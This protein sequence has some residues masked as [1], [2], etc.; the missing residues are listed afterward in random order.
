MP[1]VWRITLVS[2]L[3][4][5][6]LL[7]LLS[8]I[9]YKG[10]FKGHFTFFDDSQE[11]LQM[12]KMGHFFASF[13]VSRWFIQ[14]LKWQKVDPKEAQRI[15]VW[16]GILFVS[17]IEVLDG[18]SIAYGFSWTDILANVM[19]SLCLWLQYRVFGLIRF[20]PK[21]S[22]SFSPFASMRKEM[23]GGF[24]LSQLIKDY[25]AQTYWISCSPNL[26][27]K[28]KLFPEWLHIS[29]GYGGD[30]LLGGHDNVWEKEG[31][32]FDFSDLQRVRQ[33]Y[34]SF[35]LNFQYLEGTSRFKRGLKLV[36]SCLKFPFPMIGFD[37]VNGLFFRWL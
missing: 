31:R 22:F 2:F 33:F 3:I 5:A 23:L 25:N 24:F 1:K 7:V 37:A 20:M 27:L 26:F 10:I 36:T 18:F 6:S 9:W 16:G 17:P 34:I 12:D 14:I 28:R 29:F 8:F 19:G 11:W 35:D 30:N 15:G 4:W 21:F 32:V 13:Q